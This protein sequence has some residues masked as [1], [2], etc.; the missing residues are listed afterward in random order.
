[1]LAIGEARAAARGANA[2]VDDD[3]EDDDDED[4]GLKVT[5]STALSSGKNAGND[6]GA[7]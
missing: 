3:D 5:I 2:V 7:A 1:M 4:E 6:A